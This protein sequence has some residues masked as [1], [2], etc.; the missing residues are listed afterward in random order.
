[1]IDREEK[2]RAETKIQEMYP[3]VINVCKEPKTIKDGVKHLVTK[4]E[5]NPNTARTY[6]NFFV[7]IKKGA[8]HK[9]TWGPNKHVTYCFF[10]RI[11][12]DNKDNLESVLE[13][14]W[15]FIEY[16]EP[17]RGYTLKDFRAIH[18]EFSAKL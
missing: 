2:Q 18:E 4:L 1:M 15:N 8:S 12:S 16:N 17:R 5:M 14:L 9:S 7:K 13:S 10:E 6:I 11:F 3:V